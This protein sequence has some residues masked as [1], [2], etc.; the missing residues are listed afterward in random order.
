MHVVKTV[1]ASNGGTW[2]NNTVFGDPIRGVVK[3]CE[4]DGS[5]TPVLTPS[6]NAFSATPKTVSVGQAATLTWNIGNATSISI[7]NGV[8]TVTGSQVV[9]RPTATTTYV[10]T[11]RNTAGASTRS[12]TVSVIATPTPPAMLPSI[13]SF[14]ASP[15]SIV[16]GNSSTLSWSVSNADGVSISPSVGAVE[17]SSVAVRPT[18]NTTYTL[19]ARNTQG[20][21]TRTV[22]VAVNAAP[23]PDHSGMGPYIDRSKIPT[24][25]N[26]SAVDKLTP[27]SER[28]GRNNENVG[29]FRSVCAFSHMNFDDPMVYP[30]Q[31]GA[32]HLHAYFGNTGINAASNEQS[33]RT[34]GN[35][36]CRGGTI[37][38]SAYWVPAMIDT[39][40]GAPVKPESSHFYYKTGYSGI[41]NSVVRELPQGLRMIAGSAKSSTPQPR[42]GRFKCVNAG[43]YGSSIQNCPLGDELWQEVF[44]PQCWDGR[45]LDSP[46]HQSHMAYLENARCPASHPVVLPEISFNIVYKIREANA[47][48][49]WRLSSDMYPATS[50]G[51]YSNHGD[52]FNGWKK[53]ISD[54]FV[55]SCIQPG[56]DCHSHL[57]GDGRQMN[58]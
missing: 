1:A 6:I 30:N 40:T 47:P 18:Q 37:N 53:D 32:A 33:I 13:A 26:G 41:A 58:D 51:G 35:S 39:R 25:S 48:Q 3:R 49:R 7:N 38:R 10:L 9:V 28:P 36:T 46:D 21:V 50:P 14:G 57:I 24:G 20:A 2:C 23:P 44:F 19:T 45:N 34:T 11:A 4:V 54:T 8:G 16:A 12:V 27:T 52:W 5:P 22:V 17:G 56:L 31:P 43:T 42:S 55:R 15:A 29:A